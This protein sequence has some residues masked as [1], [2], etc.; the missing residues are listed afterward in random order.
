MLS[1]LSDPRR[2]WFGGPAAE[3][4]PTFLTDPILGLALH[5]SPRT[6]LQPH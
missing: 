2:G 6:P 1:V 3:I 4:A 5:P